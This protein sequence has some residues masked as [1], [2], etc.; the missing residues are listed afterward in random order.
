[1]QPLKL[2]AFPEGLNSF[3]RGSKKQSPLEPFQEA[4]QDS[5][6]K[7]SPFPNTIED[8]SWIC[9]KACLLDFM[10]AEPH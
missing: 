7:T 8:R 2:S 1:M 5:T 9:S 3:K 4:A 6:T 10:P